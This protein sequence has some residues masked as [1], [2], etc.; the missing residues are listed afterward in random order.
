[1]AGRINSEKQILKYVFAT[2][3]YFPPN[4]IENLLAISLQDSKLEFLS[5]LKDCP[6]EN[7][8]DRYF[9]HI[10]FEYL[11]N[12]SF[13]G[14]DRSRYYFWLQSPFEALPF[15]LYALRIPD[16]FK[17]NLKLISAF[18]DKLQPDLLK[19]NYAD[20]NAPVDS[21]KIK[22][23]LRAKAILQSH[24]TLINALRKML[25]SQRYRTSSDSKLFL[26]QILDLIHNSRLIPEVF[27]KN[28]LIRIIEKSNL[29][30]Y[31]ALATVLLYVYQVENEMIS[32]K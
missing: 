25:F 4:V 27:N 17:A 24:P 18:I 23:S 14:E 13:E 5:R 19:F 28:Y 21:F 30:Q 11:T 16:K 2:N 32:G 15:Y 8:S 31:L 22:F 7:W 12:F 29:T 3:A 6:A 20:Y 1:M 10:I 26:N 9:Y